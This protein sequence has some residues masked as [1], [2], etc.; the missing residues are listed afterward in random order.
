MADN[1]YCML[2]VI[3]ISRLNYHSRS[4]PCFG[5]GMKLNTFRA[6]HVHICCIIGNDQIQI[7]KLGIQEWRILILFVKDETERR[8][9][10]REFTIAFPRYKFEYSFE[11]GWVGTGEEGGMIS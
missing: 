7:L 6:I 1:I 4:I 10:D 11:F 8:K 5:I 9:E 2:V 3:L